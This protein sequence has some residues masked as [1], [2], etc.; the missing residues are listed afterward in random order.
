MAR[1]L[2]VDD[3]PHIVGVVRAYLERDGHAVSTASDGDRALALALAG[4]DVADPIVLD[5]MLPGRSADG[6]SYVET[7][8]GVGYRGA[9]S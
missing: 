5:V 2:V 7:V 4:D 6:G 9:R 1:I 8:R 3:E